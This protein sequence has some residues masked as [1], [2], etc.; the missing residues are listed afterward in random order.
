MNPES[1]KKLLG[2][3]KKGR[4]SVQKAMQLLKGLPFKDMGFAR[5]DTHRALRK[6]FPE[7]VFCPGKTPVQICKIMAEVLEHCECV[8]ASRADR[9]IHEAVL[10]RIPDCTYHETARVITADRRR[11]F[12]KRGLVTVCCAGTADIPVAEEARVTAEFMGAKTE[13]VYDA[14]VAGIHRLLYDTDRIQRAKCVVA[15]AGMEGALPSVVGGIASVPVIAVPTSIGYGASFGGIAPLLTMLNSCAPGVVVVNI[16][17]GFTA[18]YTAAL[19][20]N[21]GRQQ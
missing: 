18:G 6:G 12:R 10:A 19:I 17:N 3:V 15:V 14:G 21:A 9:E 8:M 11:R 7:V 20:N 13:T 5:V 2:S 1:L 16:D 4:L